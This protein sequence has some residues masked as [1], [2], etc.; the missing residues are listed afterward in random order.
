ME[1]TRTAPLFDSVS[2]Q[3]RVHWDDVDRT[4]Q[5]GEYRLRGFIVVVTLGEIE[6][7]EDHP[8]A[9][10]ALVASKTEGLERYTLGM[11]EWEMSSPNAPILPP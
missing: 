8:D 9:S 4:D 7:W 1:A 11:P 5:P 3:T 10:F 2:Y 6:I